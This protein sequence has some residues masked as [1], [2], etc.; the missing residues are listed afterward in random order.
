MR[1]GATMTALLAVAAGTACRSAEPRLRLADRL[2]IALAADAILL[3]PARVTDNES[4][5]V[6]AQ[7]FGRLARFAPGRLEPQPD[8][9]SGW[10][11]SED[12]T[13]WTF[14]LRP[15]VRFHDGTPVDAEAVV[16]SFERQIDAAHKSHE[17]DFAW[18]HAYRIIK[19]VK[20]LA[21][22]RVQFRLERPYAPFLANLA[23]VPAAI[24]SPTAVRR[25][26]GEFA[27]QPVGTGPYRFVEWIAG[28]RITLERNPDYWD[29][30]APTRTLVFQ[31]LAE[32]AQR[33]QALESGAADVIQQLAPDDVSFVRLHPGLRVVMVPAI[34]IAYLALNMRHAPFDDVRA[35][36][37]VAHALRRDA[38]VKLIYQGMAEPAVGPLP[39]GVWSSRRDLVAYPYEPARSRELLAEAGFRGDAQKPL[40]LYAPSVD[41][42]YMPG[43]DRLARIVRASLGEVGVPV[44]VVLNDF[45]EHIRAVQASEHDL[46]LLGWVGD[47]GDPD[48]FLYTLLDADNAAPGP[49]AQNIA[50]YRSKRFHELV[51]E[52][53]RTTLR[54][55]RER[56]YLEAQALVADDAP[57]VPLA[58]PRVVFAARSGVRNL[59]VQP[60]GLA[61]YR[62]A[63]VAR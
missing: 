44:R 53:Q 5:A 62:F 35:R 33:L 23:M 26:G 36:Q 16:F 31:R 25:L 63:E 32:S 20:A 12:A 30:V 61:L 2:V 46:A 50:S 18:L 59:V 10:S 22:L 13:V 27:R 60:S 21:P 47:N 34:S 38:L 15:G 28:D 57:W 11:S 4:M 7:I 1:S 42:P 8:L 54:G 40:A 24:V 19:S 3:D 9:A 43:P 52:A 39:P 6:A 29:G 56:L 49:G 45:R 17:S 37:A 55:E 48:N 51:K 58:Y 14:E 41:R